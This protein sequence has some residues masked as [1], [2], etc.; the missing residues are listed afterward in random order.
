MGKSRHFSIYCRPTL[1]FYLFVLCSFIHSS[2]STRSQLSVSLECQQEEAPLHVE[3][4]SRLPWR[5]GAGAASLGGLSRSP[6]ELRYRR[7][8][9]FWQ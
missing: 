8:R 2:F 7:L 6:S 1:L 9:C 5:L 4:G 3:A